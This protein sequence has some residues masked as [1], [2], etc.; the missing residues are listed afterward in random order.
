[1]AN[2][3]V[4]AED[5]ELDRPTLVEGLPGVGLVGK[6]ATDHL[7]DTFDMTY[8]ASIDCDGLPRLAVYEESS[9]EL[10]PPV[11][12]YADAERDLVALQS[13]V[14]V[15]A[16]AASD[17]AGC[18]SDWLDDRDATAIYMSGLP[19]Q[20]EA[21]EIPSLY[22]VA[23]GDAG[24][25][26]DEQDID[27]PNE[28]GAVSGPTGALLHE[29]G[30]RGLDS[31]GLVVES[32]PQFPD[33][34]AARI[35]IERGIAPLADVEVDT[36]DLVDRAEDITEQKEQLAQQM[37]EAETDESSQAQPLRMFQ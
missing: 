9:R 35:L 1:M 28:R 22:G 3:T 15:S 19:N 4:V 34:E 23:T 2:V 8:Y 14:P 37:Q 21:D 30:A 10:R 31:L 32:D 18:I 7:V 20:K 16:S 24:G 27:A 5:V 6:I 29:A 13:D 17:F 36:D 12:L 26:L 25:R 33:P 11:R